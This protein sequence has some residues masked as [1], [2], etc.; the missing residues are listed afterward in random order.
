[1]H[2][3][4]RMK[5]EGQLQREDHVK[6]FRLDRRKADGWFLILSI[7]YGLTILPR[8]WSNGAD[9]PLFYGMAAAWVCV[10]LCWIIERRWIPRKLRKRPEPD[11][12]QEFEINADGIVIGGAEGT[13]PVSWLRLHKYK[14]GTDLVLLYRYGG[15]NLIFPYR[16]FTPEQKDEFEG[17]LRKEIGDPAR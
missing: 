2:S 17:Y 10:P 7:G 6:A 12:P 9:R 5:I 15:E 11:T 3:Y 16:W 4:R 1:M 8:L 14:I 13:Q